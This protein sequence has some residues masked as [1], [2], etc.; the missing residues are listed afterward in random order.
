[1]ADKSI[2]AQILETKFL[3][4][5]PF[6]FNG[7][8]YKTFDEVVPGDASW[9]DGDV[10]ELVRAGRIMPFD[11]SLGSEVFPAISYLQ[12]R[13]PLG[14]AAAEL[15]DMYQTGK[16]DA[17]TDGTTDPDE[18]VQASKI[19]SVMARTLT[20]GEVQ[21]YDTSTLVP[22]EHHAGTYTSVVPSL[23]D[24][25]Q[26]LSSDESDESEDD[27][28]VPVIK[29]ETLY[30]AIGGTVSLTLEATNSPTSWEISGLPTGLTANTTTGVIT[31]EP[32]DGGTYTLAVKATNAVGS[33][34]EKSITLTISAA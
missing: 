2:G 12:R 18:L 20:D 16:I 15:R 27:S 24:V 14:F 29:T 23:V 8:H 33:S 26:P 7:V 17:N 10:I 34:E 3:V 6:K 19:L 11:D 9:S 4:R 25:D 13:S 28:D 21:T 1:M 5:V 30:C 22:Y 32:E 31:G